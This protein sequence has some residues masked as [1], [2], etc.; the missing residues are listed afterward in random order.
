MNRVV[1]IFCVIVACELV[2]ASALLWWWAVNPPPV[3]PPEPPRPDLSVLDS[4]TAGEIR[5]WQE[6]V[7]R[8]TAEDW[9]NLAEIYVIYGYFAEADLC[10]RRSVELN[11][12]SF[13][14]YYVWGTSLYRLGRTEEAAAKFRDAIPYA[15]G[16]PDG[17]SS[18]WYCIGLNLLREEKVTEA[19]SAFRTARDFFPADYELA[20][21]LVR[22]GR[23]EEAVPILDRLIVIQPKTQKFYQLRAR[24]AQA[25]GDS[26]AVADFREQAE[27]ASERLPSDGITR[28]LKTLSR[29]HGL[30]R[31][32][33][34]GQDLVQKGHFFEA[35]QLLHRALSVEWHPNAADSLITA[36]LELGHADEAIRILDEAFAR[37]GPT[38]QWLVALGDA[39]LLKGNRKQA[40]LSW[41]RAAR[42]RIDEQAHE[43]LAKYYN[44][45]GDKKQSTRHRALALHAEGREAFR[46]NQLDIA[47]AAFRKAVELAPQQAHSWYYLGEC[48]RFLKKPDSARKSYRRC[49]QIDPNH[50]RALRS[51][52]R[53]ASSQ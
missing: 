37:Y 7:S 5:E 39:H 48:L 46:K 22:S 49:L 28:F 27:R 10:C 38:P 41:E 26:E 33:Q 44:E 21:I 16:S 34:E 29:E 3:P 30:E 19:E 25:L 45:N 4:V 12:K 53:L 14:T 47:F 40:K 32:Y 24:A 18:C 51:I 36:E 15:Q 8:D 2:A 43:R 11:P 1:P 6:L 31:W 9:L 42:I 13:Y 52:E 17:V 50:G 35:A 20:R 23:A